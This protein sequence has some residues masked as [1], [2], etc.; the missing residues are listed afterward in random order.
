LASKKEKARLG[1]SL[2]LQVR[3]LPVVVSMSVPIAVGASPPW[4]VVVIAMGRP[5]VVCPNV[6]AD[7]SGSCVNIHFCERW[8]R[9]RDDERA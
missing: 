9:C 6:Y 1:P 5:T 3:F 4:C 2:R 7:P 8:H